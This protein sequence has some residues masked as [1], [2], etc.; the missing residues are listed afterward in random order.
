M[1]KPTKISRLNHNYL[2][3]YDSI[4][5]HYSYNFSNPTNFQKVAQERIKATQDLS[6]LSEI[7]LDQNK[8]WLCSNDVLRN[9]KILADKECLAVVTGQ[10]TG[11][12]GGPLYTLYKALTTIKLANY[13]NEKL[14]RPVIPVF[15]L[16]SE[17]HDFEEVRWIEFIDK[18][19]ELQHL[20]YPVTNI[21]QRQPASSIRLDTSINAMISALN[22]SMRDTD[23][24]KEILAALTDAY[25]PETT[26]SDAFGCWITHLLR[27]FGMVLLDPS[28]ARIK[29]LAKDVFVKE[30]SSTPETARK[31]ED[32]GARLKNSNY[33]QQLNIPTNRANLFWLE[34]GRHSIEV[35]NDEFLI[36]GIEKRLSRHEIIDE[37]HRMPERFS[38]NVVLR[39]IFQDTL[40]P[41]VAYVAGPGE[42]AYFAQLKPVYQFFRIPMPIIYPRA[43]FTLIEPR[44]RKLLEKYNLKETDCWGGLNKL[45][46]EVI[47]QQLLREKA[48]QI[49]ESVKEIEKHTL[50]I[51]KIIQ[52]IDPT[53]EA[54]AQKSTK[55]ISQQL[56]KLEAKLLNAQKNRDQTMRRQIQ[57]LCDF[58][59]PHEMPQERRLNILSYLFKYDCRIVEK[60]YSNIKPFDFDYNFIDL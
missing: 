31:V 11:L 40:L 13:L 57:A 25:T 42:I 28:D 4:A 8:S 1:Q 41:T 6:Q 9:I 43:S 47:K 34:N 3:S 38:P 10:Q 23:F 26:F 27:G 59:Y 50:N 21:P 14:N 7:L 12:F 45:L 19:N 39:P 5:S 17:D 49:N 33:H 48:H 58:L 22:D 46:D 35:D 53:L 18:N 16:V 15:Y 51:S 29:H 2:F 55:N 32:A 44:Y 24:K 56:A 52:H 60:I 20:E 30:L 37:A 54:V 36:R